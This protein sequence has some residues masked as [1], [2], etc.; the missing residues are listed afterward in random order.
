[1]QQEI[2]NVFDLTKPIYQC[3]IKM[4]TEKFKDSSI[5]Y[6]YEEYLE[7]FCQ[8]FSYADA[9]KYSQY[10]TLK[11][12][13]EYRGA[14]DYLITAVELLMYKKNFS[15]VLK[16]KLKARKILR[17]CVKYTNANCVESLEFKKI[18][19]GYAFY[20]LSKTYAFD[21]FNEENNINEFECLKMAISF[22]NKFAYYDISLFY[23]PD[24]FVIYHKF[25]YMMNKDELYEKMI[26]YRYKSIDLGNAEACFSFNG[27]TITDPYFVKHY[28]IDRAFLLE[29]EFRITVLAL[30][31]A[32]ERGIS[33]AGLAL[34]E[35]LFERSEF[36]C[37]KIAIDICVALNKVNFSEC[38]AT[39]FPIDL[40]KP[41]GIHKKMKPICQYI[42]HMEELHKKE[43]EDILNPD[44]GQYVINMKNKYDNIFN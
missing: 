35:M 7:F 18:K 19:L 13:P 37:Q 9:Y 31:K 15:K 10:S 40:K 20:F 16:Y 26:S 24:D 30:S 25:Q 12:D 14:V 27:W 4:A 44:S 2:K 36:E 11:K 42:I 38:P 8:Y 5:I 41:N 23:S 1:M 21:R 43:I 32:F 6:D 22:E 33:H 3:D 28:D 39:N 34:A 17:R 29:Y